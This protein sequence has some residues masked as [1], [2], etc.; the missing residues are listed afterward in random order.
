MT[1]ILQKYYWSCVGNKPYNYCFDSTFIFTMMAL[2]CDTVHRKQYLLLL[3][4]N[5]KSPN[6][7]RAS[8]DPSMAYHHSNLTA[9]SPWIICTNVEWIYIWGICVSHGSSIAHGFTESWWDWPYEH[10]QILV[11]SGFHWTFGR[12]PIYWHL[13][14]TNFNP[15]MGINYINRKVWDV[16]TYPSP[17]FNSSAVEILEWIRQF[18]PHFIVYGITY[19]CCD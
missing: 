1:Y 15:S 18:I 4:Q 9:I 3:V 17:N 11:H 13:L 10:H 6:G 2:N 12:G 16:I 14:S 7:T 8:P 19:S 5:D